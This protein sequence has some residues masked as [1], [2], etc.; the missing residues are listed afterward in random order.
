MLIFLKLT[1]KFTSSLGAFFL[2]LTISEI[3]GKFALIFL[4]TRFS[5]NRNIQPCKICIDAHQWS[6][7]EKRRLY[8]KN[9]KFKMLSLQWANNSRYNAN[10]GSEKVTKISLSSKIEFLNLM[11]VY[12]WQGLKKEKECK[13]KVSA[14]EFFKA[15]HSCKHSWGARKVFVSVLVSVCFQKSD[16][17]MALLP[18]ATWSICFSY[19]I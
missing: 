2:P 8:E 7:I 13:S 1:T 17:V 15:M 9:N 16:L 18:P 5:E 19:F 6:L 14:Q 3:I 4:T 11:N 10:I 12:F